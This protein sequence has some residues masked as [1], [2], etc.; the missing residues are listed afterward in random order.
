MTVL[1][2]QP[3][4][5]RVQARTLMSSEMFDRLVRALRRG[6]PLLDQDL[7]ERIMDQTAAFLAASAGRATPRL[8]PSPL[9]DAGWHTFLL[10][11]RDYGAFCIG[12]GG[13]VHHVPDDDPAPASGGTALARTVAA[14]TTAGYIV[15][16]DLWAAAAAECSDEGKCSAS[17]KDGNENE[18]TRIP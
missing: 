5:T 1:T 10:H 4:T 16:H 14:I 2:D 7:A 18:D 9:V 11:T 13:F 8:V 6:R 15:D 3:S 12:L 17:G